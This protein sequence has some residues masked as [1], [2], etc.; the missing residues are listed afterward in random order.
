MVDL[1]KYYGNEGIVVDKNFAFSGTSKSI[2]DL[3]SEMKANGLLVDFIDTTGVLV[4]VPVMATVNTRPDK[5]GERSGYYVYNQLDNN[6]VCVYGNWRTSQEWKFTSFNPNE[7]SVQ[8]K[9][10][11]QAKLEEAQKRREEAKKQKHK[12]VAVYS[13]EKFN[14]ADEVTEHKY[15]KDKKVNNY[16][17][18]TTNS[19]LLVP[20]YSI[21]KNDNGT[22][23]KDIKSLQYIFPDGSKK[24]VGGGEIKGN[25]FLIGCDAYELPHLPEI[26][27]CEGYATGSSIYEATGTPVAV[28]FSANFCLTACLRLRSVTNAKFVLAL[29][30]D[31]S[32]VGKKNAD[33]VASSVDNCVVRLPSLNDYNDV[34]LEVGLEQVKTELTELSFGI[35][36]YAIRN[37]VGTPPKI[38]WLVDDLLPLSINCVLAGVGGIGKSFLGIDLAMKVANGGE[39][40][41][42]QVVAKGDALIIS[43][44]DN[45]AEVWRRINEIDSHGA[46]FNSPYDVFIYTVAD[47]GKPL[48]L[49]KEDEITQKA[50]ELVEELKSFKNLKLIIL[51]PIQAFIGSSMPISS[52]NEAGQLWSTF[53]AGLS[54]QLGV[55]CISMHHMSKSALNEGEDQSLTKMRQNIRGASSII[56]GSRMA[57]VVF[58]AGKDEAEKVCYEQG[59]DFDPMKVVKGAVVKSNFKCDTS[60][61]TLFRKGAVLE[62]LDENKKS[63]EWD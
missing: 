23:A 60:I 59:Q 58:N 5:S 2:T 7:M 56:D 8:E 14:L 13:K 27:I 12:E 29:D 61:K 48:I 62:I 21:T 54:A 63:F 9:R 31:E 6:F 43:A 17:L 47:G 20:V 15:L 49:L 55:T 46:R 3:I 22:L 37:L 33:E 42:K 36:N 30:N 18:K 44:E 28:V 19:N 10:D 35:R 16:G 26:I 1:T 50:K 45:Q 38:E 51:D 25:I 32:N 11:L 34:H 4:R 39:W 41:G 40:L 57:L 52:S 53:T 24:F